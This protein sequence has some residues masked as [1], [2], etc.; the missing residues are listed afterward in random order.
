[1]YTSSRQPEWGTMV[2]FALALR[3]RQSK[4]LG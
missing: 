1:M 2:G 3:K 4:D